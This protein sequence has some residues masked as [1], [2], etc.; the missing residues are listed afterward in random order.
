MFVHACI[1]QKRY[2]IVLNQ[3]HPPLQFNMPFKSKLA[4]AEVVIRKTILLLN[5]DLPYDVSIYWVT[6]EEL[7]RRLIHSGVR[8]SLTLI[9][10]Q[11][12]LKRNNKDQVHLTV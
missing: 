1:Y 12:S 2:K 8:K 3:S 9:M 6:A 5:N 11:E 7:W 4:P 10:V